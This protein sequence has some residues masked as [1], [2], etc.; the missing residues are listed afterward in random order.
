MK[1]RIKNLT[2]QPLRF[3]FGTSQVSLMKRSS[4]KVKK[5]TDQMLNM[6]KK[7]LIKITKT[8]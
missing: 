4:M 8:R 1:Y 3:V 7:G 2:F 6:H 5:I